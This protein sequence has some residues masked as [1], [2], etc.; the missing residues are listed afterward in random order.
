MLLEIGAQ[1]LL[2]VSSRKE[3]NGT[4]KL[5]RSDGERHVGQNGFLNI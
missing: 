4:I 1:E 5:R 3:K 2:A